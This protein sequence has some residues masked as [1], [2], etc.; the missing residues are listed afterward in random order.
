LVDIPLATDQINFDLSQ[1]AGT[2]KNV[3]NVF[4]HGPSLEFQFLF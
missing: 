4:F 2:Q 3:G 1:P